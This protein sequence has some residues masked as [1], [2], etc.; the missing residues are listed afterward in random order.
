MT[1]LT[2]MRRWTNKCLTMSEPREPRRAVGIG[3]A[4]VLAVALVGAGI[5]LFPDFR[6]YMKIE[7][8]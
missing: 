8:I 1:T 2:P 4:A 5:W 7:R 3:A 6:R